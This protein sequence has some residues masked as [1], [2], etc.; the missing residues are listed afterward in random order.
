MRQAD[1]EERTEIKELF[2]NSFTQ[3]FGFP[4]KRAANKVTSILRESHV[5]FIREAPVMVMATSDATGKCDA[6]PKGGL[7]GFVKVLNEETLLLPDVAGNKL[8]QSYQ[9]IEE[10]PNIGLIFFIPGLNETLRINGRAKIISQNEVIDM[11]I[12]LEVSNPD[13]D[14]KIL[15]GVLVEVDE[16]YG[17]CPRAFNFSSLWDINQINRNKGETAKLNG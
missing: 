4:K 17:H 11:K 6:S 15:Q 10:N 12:K 1:I 9:N 5:N 8:F 2:D 13:E 14:A 7:P 16:A 3:K